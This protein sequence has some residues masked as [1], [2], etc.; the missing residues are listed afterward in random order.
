MSPYDH[1]TQKRRFAKSVA[2]KMTKIVGPKSRLQRN[3]EREMSCALTLVWL[4]DSFLVLLGRFFEGGFLIQN[5]MI[6][7]L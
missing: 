5:A 3:L 4:P 1:A 7:G 6:L 2:T